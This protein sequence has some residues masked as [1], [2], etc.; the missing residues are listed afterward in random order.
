MISM[1]EEVENKAPERL[2]YHW[3]WVVCIRDFTDQEHIIHLNFGNLDAN[4]MITFDMTLDLF[5][6]ILSHSNFR[7]AKSLKRYCFQSG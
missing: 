1:M 6:L 3:P 7:R 5:V 2:G 4:R